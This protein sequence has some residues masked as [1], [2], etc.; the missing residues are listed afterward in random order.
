VI[1]TTRMMI[2]LVINM[3]L[4]LADGQSVD[5]DVGDDHVAGDNVLTI[6][7]TQ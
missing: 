2:K 6:V 1:A 4:I 3:T 5:N 7:R